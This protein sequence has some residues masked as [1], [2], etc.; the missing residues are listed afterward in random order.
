MTN[1]PLFCLPPEGEEKNKEE[2]KAENRSRTMQKLQLSDFEETL[3][4]QCG[5]ERALT[6]YRNSTLLTTALFCILFCAIGI[7]MNASK[8][9]VVLML[10]YAFMNV[11]ELLG[12][13]RVGAAYRSL[14]GKLAERLENRTEDHASYGAIVLQSKKGGCFER[15]LKRNTLLLFSFFLVMVFFLGIRAPLEYRGL[16]LCSVF[17]FY[18]LLVMILKLRIVRHLSCCK[19][20]AFELGKTLNGLSLAPSAAA[21]GK[22]GK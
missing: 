8:M 9:V 1:F 11:L 13:A 6:R 2:V 12:F 5:S 21:A 14:I 18:S 4:V 22:E 20:Q 17:V 19:K 10:I 15:S 3:Y 16:L 7:S